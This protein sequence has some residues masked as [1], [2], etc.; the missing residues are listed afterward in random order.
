MVKIKKVRMEKENKFKK[1]INL[2]LV[3]GDSLY[4]K[5]ESRMECSRQLTK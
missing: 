2:V 4:L 1:V 5:R 3:L